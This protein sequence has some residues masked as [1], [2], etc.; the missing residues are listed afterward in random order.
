[1]KLI[2]C[3]GFNVFSG[4]LDEVDIS[5][6]NKLLNT[7]SP[8]S[9]GISTTDREFR[10]ALK[11]SDILVL[12]G[13]Y[14]GLSGLLLQGESIIKNQGP[15]VFN[16]FMK[17]MN[18]L[19]GRVFLLGSKDAVLE[20]MK[21]RALI[22]YPNVGVEYFSPPFKNQFS[23]EDNREMIE[24]INGYKPDVLFVGM[25]C[26]KQEKWSFANKKNINANLTCSIGAVFDWY[27]GI[28]PIPP[29][30][31]KL[32][33]AWLK[34]AIDRPE[35]LK[36]YPNIGIFIWHLFL[37]LIGFKKYKQGSF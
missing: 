34:R 20:K 5:K 18:T 12:D 33:L 25:T 14:F 17:K 7:I 1:M 8:I 3:M 11:A 36:R 15:D 19:H 21:L 27:A 24:K 29:V 26:P 31:W 9:Y 2:N 16:F 28:N 6:G 23:D 35:I 22:D 4:Y 30:W 37:A 10:Q 32:R 13:V